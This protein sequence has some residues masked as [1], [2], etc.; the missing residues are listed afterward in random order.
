M[1][2][3]F[4]DEDRMY[5]ALKHGNGIDGI[6]EEFFTGIVSMKTKDTSRELTITKVIWNSRGFG[7][8]Y[9]DSLFTWFIS[10][11]LSG[12]IKISKNDALYIASSYLQDTEVRK[13]F[14]KYFNI[15]LFNESFLSKDC[16][17]RT[18]V[19]IILVSH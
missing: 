9:R 16:A 8:A 6:L 10:D 2:L 14:A 19:T 17:Y 5:D 4:E 11:C 7:V 18:P 3:A 13:I 12:V 1:F 15:L